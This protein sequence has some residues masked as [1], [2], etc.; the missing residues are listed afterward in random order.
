MNR[1]TRRLALGTTLLVVS[2]ALAACDD[3]DPTGA[4]PSGAERVVVRIGGQE[5]ASATAAAAAGEIVVQIGTSTAPIQVVF[6]DDDGDAVEPDGDF[7]LEVERVGGTVATFTPSAPGAFGGTVSGSVI[8]Q[9][10]LVFKLMRGEPG[11]GQEDFVP[12]AITVRVRA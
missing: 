6:V 4:D 5:V 9:T 11:S 8:G 10:T 12:A 1:P 3:G 2:G 7:H